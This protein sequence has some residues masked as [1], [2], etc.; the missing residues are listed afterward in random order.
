MKENEKFTLKQGYHLEASYNNLTDK[1]VKDLIEI[2]QTYPQ[3]TY[4]TL[5][6][7]D[8]NDKQ[9]VALIDSKVLNQIYYL[10]LHVNN[11]TEQG[12]SV[13]AQHLKYTS[14][15][16][17]NLSKNPIGKIGLQ[18]IAQHLKESKITV[19]NLMSIPDK[20]DTNIIDSFITALNESPILQYVMGIGVKKGR[21]RF[22]ELEKRNRENIKLQQDKVLA[23]IS[24]L[25]DKDTIDILDKDI[26]ISYELIFGN[27]FLKPNIG[28]SDKIICK[29]IDYHIN[30]NYFKI[31]EVIQNRMDVDHSVTGTTIHDLP[32]EILGNIFQYCKISD[33][34]LP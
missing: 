1:D 22:L 31:T 18:S 8:I 5:D 33:V 30:D 3:I 17:L 15:C 25:K 23:L 14:I 21:E 16:S 26:L 2:I 34:S 27:A 9:I 13:L 20:E 28:K 10:D 7:M 6:H 12:A 24:D 32:T 11:I 4:L 19:L 29:R